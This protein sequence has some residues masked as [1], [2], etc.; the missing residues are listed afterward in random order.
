M[1]PKPFTLMLGQARIVIG[2]AFPRRD[3][4]KNCILRVMQVS[5]LF[6]HVSQWEEQKK[7]T[8]SSF[9]NP[10]RLIYTLQQ[11]GTLEVVT[12]LLRNGLGFLMVKKKI[13]V[14]RMHAR[15]SAISRRIISD[16]ET[17]RHDCLYSLVAVLS[18]SGAKID[19]LKMNSASSNAQ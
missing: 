12:D 9:S 3:E 19:L 17:I 5:C 2:S 18:N 16:W 15:F 1:D 14:Q 13:P 11:V 4:L 8:I 7:D 10:T 6:L